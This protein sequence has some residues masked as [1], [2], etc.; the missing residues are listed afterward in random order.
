MLADM[1]EAVPN[2]V[3]HCVASYMSKNPGK[4]T[5]DA[6]PICVSTMQ[7]AG[8]VEPGSL[9]LTKV[10]QSRETEH[11]AE[12]DAAKKMNRYHGFLKQAREEALAFEQLRVVQE[13]MSLIAEEHFPSVQAVPGEVKAAVVSWGRRSAKAFMVTLL[14]ERGLEP[15][16]SLGETIAKTLWGLLKIGAAGAIGAMF[17]GVASLALPTAEIVRQGIER[18]I[19]SARESEIPAVMK[20]ALRYVATAQKEAERAGD[21]MT[22]LFYEGLLAGLL[23]Y[24]KTIRESAPEGASNVVVDESLLNEG[25]LANFADSFVALISRWFDKR[26]ATK[27]MKV[28]L[29]KLNVSL[30]QVKQTM[31]KIEAMAQK[32]G[33]DVRVD[34]N[35]TP[36]G[37]EMRVVHGGVTPAQ[38]PAAPT[39]RENLEEAR[40]RSV[41]RPSLPIG[42]IRRWK[43]EGKTYAMVKVAEPSVWIHKKNT[44]ERGSKAGLRRGAVRNWRRG[45]MIKLAPGRWVRKKGK[46]SHESLEGLPQLLALGRKLEL[47]ESHK[48]TLRRQLDLQTLHE[49]CNCGCGVCASKEPGR[50]LTVRELLKQG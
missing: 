22:A 29:N 34:V 12:P 43:K 33:M 5:K 46:Y 20:E 45:A 23:D 41:G 1:N 10:G 39:I 14:R 11:E 17:G 3:R 8:Y 25:K 18:G 13:E 19:E 44:E 49:G 26:K 28:Q 50:K 30:M 42:A 21:E 16:K 7:K 35:S 4:S 32:L 38:L 15:Q 31:A 36:M 40:L 6:F 24:Q 48:E 9:A 27:E 47:Q 37:L 2:L